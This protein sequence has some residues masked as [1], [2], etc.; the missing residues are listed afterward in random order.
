MFPLYIKLWTLPELTRAS[1][2]PLPLLPLPSAVFF[3][4]AI[5]TNIIVCS[6]LILGGA[7]VMQALTGMNL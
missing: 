6:M 2:P 7:S 1:P 4:F 3:C 5:T